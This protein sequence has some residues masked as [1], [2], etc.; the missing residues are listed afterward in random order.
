MSL[1]YIYPANGSQIYYQLS[2]VAGIHRAGIDTSSKFLKTHFHT[3]Y[4]YL[5]C[6]KYMEQIVHFA[7]I[8]VDCECLKPKKQLFLSNQFWII[9]MKKFQVIK[10]LAVSSQEPTTLTRWSTECLK[11]AKLSFVLFIR[12]G[13][14]QYSNSNFIIQC[15]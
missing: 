11:N 1:A 9:L 13:Q 6:R 12:I 10:I 4:T 2:S 14:I 7:Q 3:L 15:V 5:V 8:L